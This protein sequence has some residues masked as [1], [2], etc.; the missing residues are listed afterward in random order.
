MSRREHVERD[1]VGLDVATFTSL[2]ILDRVPAAFETREQYAKWRTTVGRGLEV[3]PLSLVIVGSA[4]VGLSLSPGEKY[5]RPFQPQS[6]IDLA[7]I[8]PRHFDES[9]RWLRSLGPLQKLKDKSFQ[10]QM[11]SWHRRSLIFDGTIAAERLL[12]HLSFGPA[13]ATTL[14]RAG[15]MDPT[16]DRDVK[17]RI[18]RDFESLRQ[19]HEKNVYA[20]RT[21]VLVDQT[22]PEP[23]PEPFADHQV[24]AEGS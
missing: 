16:R 11:Q 2:H 1:L 6:D 12:A 21:A 20:L 14:G 22:P 23:E 4:A 10:G 18:Y 8:S 5:L 7:V 24:G 17:A 15:K 19:Y 13:W 9:W 3:D